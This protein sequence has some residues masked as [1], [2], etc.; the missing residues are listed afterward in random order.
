LAAVKAG[1]AP[2]VNSFGPGVVE[3][4]AVSLMTSPTKLM[5]APRKT[6]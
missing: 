3:V 6:I 5:S 4:V 1:V 2:I